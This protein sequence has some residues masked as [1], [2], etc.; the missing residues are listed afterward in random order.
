MQVSSCLLEAESILKN[1][2]VS[3]LDEAAKAAAQLS[4]IDRKLGAIGGGNGRVLKARK[5]VL[6]RL[7]DLKI[8]SIG[9]F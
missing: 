2:N 8:K 5:Y 1:V 6:E 4:E 7:R 9:H 3:R